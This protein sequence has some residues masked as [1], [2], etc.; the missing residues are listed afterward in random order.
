MAAALRRSATVTEAL[1]RICAPGFF[2]RR[3][4]SAARRVDVRG[5]V[6]PVAPLEVRELARLAAG[7]APAAT[8]WLLV[9]TAR[10]HCS[11][12]RS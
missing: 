2:R 10:A 9:L 6:V 11:S 1:V 8:P 4:W 3:L 7:R 5:A 12:S